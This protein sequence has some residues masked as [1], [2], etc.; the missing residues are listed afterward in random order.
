MKNVKVFQIILHKCIYDSVYDSPHIIPKENNISGPRDL[1]LGI[2]WSD[3]VVINIS[4]KSDN[5]H[6]IKVRS[7]LLK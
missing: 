3:A 2:Q 4:S 1:K 6:V 7:N 5:M